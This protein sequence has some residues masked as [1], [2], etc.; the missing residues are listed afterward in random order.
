MPVYEGNGLAID[1]SV[2]GGKGAILLSE[3]DLHCVLVNCR[4]VYSVTVGGC[5][6][7]RVEP[8]GDLSLSGIPIENFMKDN[9]NEEMSRKIVLN[10][11]NN[12]TEKP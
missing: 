2:A 4:I 6:P 12:K 8:P 9:L 11:L 7:P 3:T 5:E 10:Y 1:Y